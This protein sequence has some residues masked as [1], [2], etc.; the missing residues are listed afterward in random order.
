MVFLYEFM[1][2]VVT[3]T[4]TKIILFSILYAKEFQLAIFTHCLSL[5]CVVLLCDR[6]LAAGVHE[7]A[8]VQTWGVCMTGA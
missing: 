7:A 3:D 5:T 1:G 6:D 2:S 4:Q 8:A